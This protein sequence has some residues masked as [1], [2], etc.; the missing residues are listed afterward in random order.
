MTR[1]MKIA[2][3]ASGAFSALV[4][5]ILVLLANGVVTLQLALL[6]VVALVGLYFGFGVLIWIYRFVAKLD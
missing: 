6:M 1:G 3:A 5:L 2:A 4:I